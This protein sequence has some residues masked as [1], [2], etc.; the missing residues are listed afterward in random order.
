MKIFICMLLSAATLTLPVQVEASAGIPD[1]TH[2]LEY[3]PAEDSSKGA[4]DFRITYS[5]GTV[6]TYD[7]LHKPIIINGELVKTG[8]E[9]VDGRTFVSIRAISEALGYASTWSSHNRTA[10]IQRGDTAI[11]FGIGSAQA[12]INGVAAMMDAPPAI[13]EGYTHIPLSFIAR[14]FNATVTYSTEADFL[15]VS[16]VNGNVTIDEAKTGG[17]SQEEAAS[18]TKNEIL[19]RFVNFKEFYSLYRSKD[20]KSQK[21]VMLRHFSRLEA[22]INDVSVIGSVSRYYV[23]KGPKR[24]LADKLS[25]AIFFVI[26]SP[27]GHSVV[28]LNES[29]SH[30]LFLDYFAS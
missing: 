27:N 6:A 21:E 19:S 20:S 3:V 26:D 13:I 14:A 15:V 10:T 30:D 28:R 18:L 12:R 29:N 22:M 4:L 23:L 5:D 7:G 25:G 16:G 1:P 8:V 9:T 2:K 24:I 11:E 17:L